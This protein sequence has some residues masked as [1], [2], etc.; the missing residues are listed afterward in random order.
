MISAQ[1]I[2]E[3]E[4]KKLEVR[5]STYKAILEQLCRKI[6]YASELGDQ[7]TFL[8]VPPFV[9]GYPAYDIDV[10][11]A[12]IQRQLDR[13]GYKVIKVAKATLGVSWGGTKPKGPV[14]I[15]HSGE[16]TKNIELP[17]LANL[18]KTAAKIR[19]KK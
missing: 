14:I 3:R 12:Y 5:K 18:Q 16:E 15:D 9:I 19:G 8:H 4:K 6:K 7:S 11:T 2:A 13:L 17:T 10:A 1:E